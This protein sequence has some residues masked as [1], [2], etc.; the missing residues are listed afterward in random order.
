MWC[1]ILLLLLGL[2]TALV[3]KHIDQRVV[4]YPHFTCTQDSRGL[5][6]WD[7]CDTGFIS[8]LNPRCEFQV[9]SKGRI[10]QE[11]CTMNRNVLCWVP[12]IHLR[13]DRQNYSRMVIHMEDG[14][15]HGPLVVVMMVTFVLTILVYCS[16]EAHSHSIV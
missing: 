9:D 3:D 5:N 14:Q 13:V 2:F 4:T 7:P 6:S 1:T 16:L 10:V 8:M 12:H 15:V 11:K